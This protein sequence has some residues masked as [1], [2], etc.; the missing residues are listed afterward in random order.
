M[1]TYKKMYSN[2]P[3]TL[4]ELKHNIC[5]TITSIMV[6]GIKLVSNSLSKTPEVCFRESGMM[7]R[8]S[9]LNKCI[10]MSIMHSILAT[11]LGS[12]QE[13][14]AKSLANL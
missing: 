4:H 5:K 3:H 1:E 9:K 12:S 6:N 7:V 14:M 13:V 10:S 11:N 8:F 2:N